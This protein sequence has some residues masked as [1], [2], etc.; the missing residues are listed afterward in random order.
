[1]KQGFRVVDA[2]LRDGRFNVALD[3]AMIELHHAA[4][5]PDTIRFIHFPPTALVGRHQVLSREIDLDYCARHGI[6]VGRRITGG[7]AIYLDE[8]QLGWALVFHR[9][10]LG[11]GGLADVAQAICEAV[12]AGL[13][14][15]GVDARYRP[16]NDVEVDGR[17][18]SGTGGFFDG[19]TLI[20]Q[21]TVLI[22][23]DPGRMMSALKV[24]EAKL[25]RHGAA[26]AAQRVVTLRE[27]LGSR[28]PALAEIQASLLHGFQQRLGLEWQP[29]ALTAGEESLARRLFDEE[30]GQDAFVAEIDEP[31]SGEAFL[32]GSHSC[33]GGAITA[34]VRLEGVAGDRIGQ[35]LFT[36]DFFVAPPR[37]VLDLESSLKGLGKAAAGDAVE[38]FFAQHELAA[39]TVTPADFRRALESALGPDAGGGRETTP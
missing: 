25:A 39:L 7:G 37:A 16:R 21:G 10:T 6:G 18:I 26:S 24:P 22:D 29:G 19:D 15:L 23:T 12:A 8:G 32:V 11:L 28:T 30:L 20:Y 2:G 33:P 13:S 38:Q 36:G 4:R 1:M 14:R 35:V 31:E 5:I 17:K 3:Q 9:R 34:Y 27:L